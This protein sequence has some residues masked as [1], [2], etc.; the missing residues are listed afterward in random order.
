MKYRKTALFGTAF[1]ASMSLAAPA[2]A[3]LDAGTASMILQLTVGGIFGALMATRLYWTKL[4]GFFVR[5]R[6]GVDPNSEL[7]ENSN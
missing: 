4:K 7:D 6:G 1:V 3:Y 2:Y 5:V